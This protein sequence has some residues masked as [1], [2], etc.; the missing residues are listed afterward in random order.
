MRSVPFKLFRI[1]GVGLIQ[2]PKPNEKIYQ[3][4]KAW[5]TDFGGNHFPQKDLTNFY[6]YL[7]III[8]DSI[9]NHQIMAYFF[10]V[11]DS[12]DIISQYLVIFWAKIDSQ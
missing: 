7:L 8:I 12:Y 6:F 1:Y 10:Y 5:I 9:L 4:A 2:G 3:L 11:E